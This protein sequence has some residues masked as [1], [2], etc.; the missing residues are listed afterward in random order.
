MNFEQYTAKVDAILSAQFDGLSSIESPDESILPICFENDI[1]VMDCA[2]D[3]VE[4]IVQC[5]GIFPNG[6]DYRNIDMLI[7]ELS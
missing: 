3:I 2:A 4:S 6:I 7:D 5:L 1:P